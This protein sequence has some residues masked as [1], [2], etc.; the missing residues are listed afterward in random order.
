LSDLAILFKHLPLPYNPEP[1]PQPFNFPGMKNEPRFSGKQLGFYQ[2][3]TVVEGMF[4]MPKAEAKV[5]SA[6]R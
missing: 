3:E 2:T 5:Y 1:L 4:P 6:Q